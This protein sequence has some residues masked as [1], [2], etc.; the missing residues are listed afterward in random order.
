MNYQNLFI[1]NYQAEAKLIS[2][3]ADNIFKIIKLPIFFN[4]NLA[5]EI[6]S[7]KCFA[8][9]V[10][11][12]HISVNSLQ[13]KILDNLYKKEKKEFAFTRFY[14]M[15]HLSSDVSEQGTYHYD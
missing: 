15:I 1:S 14:P 12:Y 8:R 2:D 10:I 7:K 4:Q 5:L 9:S 11:R 6:E 3:Q 13:K